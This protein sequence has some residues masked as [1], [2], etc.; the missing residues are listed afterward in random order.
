MKSAILKR[1]LIPRTC[2]LLLASLT[3]AYICSQMAYMYACKER[4]Q[5][6]GYW[7]IQLG[8]LEFRRRLRWPAEERERSGVGG[9]A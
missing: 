2:N 5:I 7:R 4:R 3:S 6:L 8:V 9:S 1:L